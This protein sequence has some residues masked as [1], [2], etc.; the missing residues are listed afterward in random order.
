MDGADLTR[1]LGSMEAGRLIILCGAG[2]SMAPPS[3]LPA[4]WKVAAACYDKYVLSLDPS[5]PQAVRE[6]LE[7][8]AEI[9][10]L[11]KTLATVFIPKLV[12][13]EDFVRPPNPGHAAVADFL[14][15]G[16]ATAALSGNYDYLIERCAQDYGFDLL[17]SLDGDEATAR[18]VHHSPLLKFHGCSVRD[19][20]ATVWTRSQIASDPVIQQRLEKT[21]TWMA[22][23]LREKDLLVVGFW[24]DWAYL[25]AVL[26]QVIQ[27]VS[28]LS[29][30]LIDPSSPETLEEKAPDLWAVAHRHPVNFFHIRRSGAEVLDQLRRAFSEGFLRK[31]LVS[32]RVALEGTTGQPCDPAWLKAPELDSEDLYAWRRDAEGVPAT[33]PATARQPQASEVVGLVHLLLRRAGASCK[34]YGYD[35]AG[36][37]VRVVN[38]AGNLLSTVRERFKEPPALDTDVVVCAGA[39]DLGLPGNVVRPGIPGSIVR[40]APTAKWLDVASACAELEL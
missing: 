11:N 21:K 7:L 34:P 35:L 32:G 6:D 24:S 17:A 25:N 31:V 4:A 12:P 18:S 37:T 16:I 9:F 23:N 20:A 33:R 36:K 27:A 15:T 2:L 38:G 14:I 8:L 10:A 1:L 5:C 40:P 19:R 13:W 3:C 30:T 29:L 22:A 39:E 28:P 26:G